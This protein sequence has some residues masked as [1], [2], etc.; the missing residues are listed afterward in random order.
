MNIGKTRNVESSV[1]EGNEVSD[2]SQQ[3]SSRTDDFDWEVSGNDVLT[4]HGGGYP[5]GSVGIGTTSPSAKLDVET[6]HGEGGA[7]TIGSSY[8]IATG[9]FAIALGAYTNASGRRAIAMG[10]NT[11]A[12]GDHST[13]IGQ[14]TLASNYTSTAMGRITTASGQ[15]STAMGFNTTASGAFSTAIGRSIIV[16]GLNSLGIGLK[17][18][19]PP[20]T[21]SNSYV[22]SI[23]GGKVGIGTTSPSYLL[24]VL[25]EGDIV[26][27]F[28]GRVKGAQA[29]ND[30]EFVTKAQLKDKVTT[31]YTPTGTS[32][33]NGD[34][35][36]TT[37]DD[38]YFYV[39][40]PDGWKRTA[41][42]TWET[43]DMI[44]K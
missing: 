5:S 32:D 26:A 21:V 43:T 31:N 6:G 20:Y 13:A 38:N 12:S 40:T 41:L 14:F 16:E 11:I 17:D 28:S 37:W 44:T 19:D 22:M 25:G 1:V 10:S 33:S 3:Y 27:Q 18:N 30:D 8:N 7:A 39:K 2:S 35:G 42:K 9:E 4:E 34:V 36:D 24:H 29:V 23:I 15:A